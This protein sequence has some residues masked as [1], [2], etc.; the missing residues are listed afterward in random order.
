MGHHLPRPGKFSNNFVILFRESK[1]CYIV[2][3]VRVTHDFSFVSVKDMLIIQW[4]RDVG[5]EGLFVWTRQQTDV[6][7]AQNCMVHE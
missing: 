6:D 2:A 1:Q 4:V 3:L 7:A 5:D